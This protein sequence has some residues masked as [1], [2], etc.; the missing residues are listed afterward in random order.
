[1]RQNNKLFVVLVV[2]LLMLTNSCRKPTGPS[3]QGPTILWSRTYGG[4]SNDEGKS[5]QQTSDGGYIIVGY[6]TSMG[7]GGTDVYLIKTNPNGDILWAKTYG[8]ISDD[9]GKSVQQTSDGGYI[10]AGSTSSFGAGESNVY[11]VKTNTSGDTLWTKTYGG[12]DYAYGESIQE[13]SDGGYIIT[14]SEGSNVYLI[15]ITTTGETLWSR[16]FGGTKFSVGYSIQQT[17]DGGYII[18]GSIGEAVPDVYLL[19]TD[20]EGDTIWT[21]T[22]SGISYDCGYSVR[23]TS[24]GGYIITGMTISDRG[25]IDIY[26]IKTDKYGSVSWTRVYGGTDRDVGLAVREDFDGGYIIAG[27]TESFGA[28]MSDVYLVKTDENGETIWTKT[29]GGIDCD[30]GYSVQSTSDG[31]FVIVG[32]TQ[33]FGAG[34]YDVY[35]IKIK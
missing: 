8:G 16:T 24:D 19:K 33:S 31:G 1:V 22:I 28:G 20:A 4:A 12:T 34:F 23:Q 7:T 21:K 6:T 27:Y 14:G 17:S 2:L 32:G 13:I 10:I 30:F 18:A 5:V 35:F 9:E 15:K 25:W 3:G 11:V 29:F 26:L